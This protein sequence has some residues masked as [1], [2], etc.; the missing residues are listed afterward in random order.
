MGLIRKSLSVGTIGLVSFRSKK[1]RLQRAE[2]SQRRAETSLAEE[3]EARTAAEARAGRAERRARRATVKAELKSKRRHRNGRRG[4]HSESAHPLADALAGAE[5]IIQRTIESAVTGS[6][7]VAA[8]T[9]R[10]GRRARK[11]AAPH[12]EALANRAS[13][14]MKHTSS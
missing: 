12:V 1:E 14:A 3:H 4:R 8:E 2:R 11:A 7:H 9:R 10:A 5:P 13:E 6:T